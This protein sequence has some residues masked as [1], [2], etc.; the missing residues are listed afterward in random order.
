MI[1]CRPMTGEP[2]STRSVVAVRLL[3]W[4]SR[5]RW[6]TSLLV[7]LDFLDEL[8]G[9]GFVGAPDLQ[10]TFAIHY[11]TAALL[12][13]VVPQLTGLLIEPPLFLLADR[14]RRKWLVIGGMVALGACDLVAGLSTSVW[15]LAG[16]WPS[17]G[18]PATSASTW[19][20]PR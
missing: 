5:A 10:S 18:P 11:R 6:L 15:T 8:G 16:R 19:P 14:V 1:S 13:F 9:V 7:C 17:P 3:P 2:H 4:L 20:R 12:L